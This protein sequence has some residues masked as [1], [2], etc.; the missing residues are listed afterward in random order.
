MPSYKEGNAT[1]LDNSLALWTSE[2]GEGST[3]SADNVF[4]IIAGKAGE[5]METGRYLELGRVE[6]QGALLSIVNAM[7]LTNKKS[8]GKAMNP[9]SLLAEVFGRNLFAKAPTLHLVFA[10]IFDLTHDGANIGFS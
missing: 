2:T 1:I 5:A 4:F 9:K 10:S 3:H 7:G 6:H 8:I